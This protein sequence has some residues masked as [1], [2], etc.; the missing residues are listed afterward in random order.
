MFSPPSGDLGNWGAIAS[1]I[2][3]AITT[4]R[5]AEASSTGVYGGLGLILVPFFWIWTMLPI[6][7]PPPQSLISGTSTALLFSVLLKIPVLLADIGTGILILKLVTRGTGSSDRGRVAFLVWYLNPFNIYW[8]NLFGGMDIIPAFILM[9]GLTFGTSEKWLRCGFSLAIGAI[10]RIFPVFTVP[11]LLSALRNK[12]RQTL[13]LLTGFLGPM[14]VGAIIVY[15]IGAGTFTSMAAT[16]ER[17]YWLLEFLGPS[18]GNSYVKLT[19]VVLALQFFVT[20]RYWEKPSVISLATVSLLALLTGAQFY[21]GYARH[22]L[23]VSPLLTTT[24]MLNR[25]EKWLFIATFLA[26]SLA[27]SIWWI[28]IPP[29][30]DTLTAGAFWATKA[31]YLLRINLDNISPARFGRENWFLLHRDDTSSGT[32]RGKRYPHP[33]TIRSE[34]LGERF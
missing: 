23:W 22:F 29:Y 26:G 11:F 34:K 30:T 6:A 7:H 17:Q 19:Y 16:P 31:T 8:I 5:Y 25:N 18:L 15:G 21:G 4:G 12:N 14:L 2:L 9:L 3:T 24:V 1:T 13:Y 27:P 28:S 32:Q 10:T 20:Y 33:G